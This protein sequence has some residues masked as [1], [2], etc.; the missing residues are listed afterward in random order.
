MELV[1]VT[2]KHYKILQVPEEPFMNYGKFREIRERL[3]L[4][5]QRTCF[6][7]ERKFKDSE[8]AFLIFTN[9]GNKLVCDKCHDE[10]IK[11]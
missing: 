1:K 5:V 2:R 11:G 3:G 4:K 8:D 7:C 10:I 6:K 9:K